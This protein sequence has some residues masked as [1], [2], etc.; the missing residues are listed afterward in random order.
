MPVLSVITVLSI[1][2][3]LTVIAFLTNA[4]L[5]LPIAG[6]MLVITA[7][8][9]IVQLAYRRYGIIKGWSI[10]KRKF[11]IAA[12]IHHHFQLKGFKD[13]TIVM[14]YWIITAVASMTAL[15]IYLLDKGI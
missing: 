11:F 3:P 14:R 15:M 5:L 10:K 4:V 7:G 12:P 6:I 13:E 9:D 1:P 8:S 2:A